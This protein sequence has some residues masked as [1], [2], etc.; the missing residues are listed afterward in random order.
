MELDRVYRCDVLALLSALEDE[1][2]DLAIADPPYNMGKGE[3]DTFPDEN[4]Y[5]AFMDAWLDALLPKL[6]PTASLYLFNNA[7][8][9]AHTLVRLESRPLIL[10][11]WITWYK[12]DGFSSTHKKYV[13]SQETILF[14]TRGQEY[15]FHPDDIRVPY[16]STE[17]M[18]HAAKKGILKNGKRW[19][20]NPQGRLCSDVWEISSRRHKEKVNGKILTPAHPTQ[21]PL[22]MIERMV[23]ASSSPGDV[24]LDLFSGTGTTSLVAQRLGRRFVGCEL[25]EEYLDI[26]ESEGIPVGGL[27]LPE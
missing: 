12:K 13:N 18:K 27:P 8:N 2:V 26:I 9:S 17:R 14:Y 4:A 5:H 20:P 11:N 15:T 16:L 1:S 24:V 7:C 6:K 23:L 3:W 21:K 25:C 19:F 22:E 10:R